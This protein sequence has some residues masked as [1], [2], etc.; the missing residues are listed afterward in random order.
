MTTPLSSIIGSGHMPMIGEA[1]LLP[2][3]LPPSFTHRGATFITTGSW[4]RAADTALAGTAFE[5]TDG[6]LPVAALAGMDNLFGNRQTAAADGF[7]AAANGS[8]ALR[9][10]QVLGGVQSEIAANVTIPGM[11]TLTGSSV[12][13]WRLGS[14]RFVTTRDQSAG[15]EFSRIYEFDGTALIN[16]FQAA[17]Q[18]EFFWR[19]RSAANDG[20]TGLL[21]SE[22]GNRLFRTAD[23]GTTWA[24]VT[25]PVTGLTRLHAKTGL[26]VVGRNSGG[27]VYTSPT[28]AGG[29]WTTRTLPAGGTV[30][31]VM[32]TPSGALLAVADNNVIYRSPDDGATWAAVHTRANTAVFGFDPLNSRLIAGVSEQGGPLLISINDGAAWTEAGTG[33][34]EN[35]GTTNYPTYLVQRLETVGRTGTNQPTRLIRGAV[36]T[37]STLTWIGGTGSMLAYYMRVA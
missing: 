28:G 23:G 34:F 30:R 20:N 37:G 13:G 2:P 26:F 27:N 31:D 15:T 36:G 5:T 35:F 6:R 7:Y 32:F 14:R 29:S 11:V 25:P 12:W 21:L 16:R 22:P 19:P 4:V 17:D 9:L 33:F 18:M 24:L 1:I 10:S 8:T 3:H